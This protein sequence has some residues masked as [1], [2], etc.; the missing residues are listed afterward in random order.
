MFEFLKR[1]RAAAELEAIF[2][3]M[4]I[5]LANN[6]KSPAHEALDKLCARTEELHAAALLSERDYRRFSAICTEYREMLKDYHH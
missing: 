5:D 3:E 6:Y 1:R 2:A 4:K